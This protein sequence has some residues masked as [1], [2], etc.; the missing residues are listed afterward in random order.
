MAMKVSQLMTTDARACWSNESLD[1]AA[2]LMWERDCGSLPVLDQNGRVLGM[3]TDRDVCMAAYTQARLLGQIPVSEAMSRE[4]H[5]CGP[6]E[7]LDEVEKIMRDHQV[8]RLAV[9]DEKGHLRGIVSLADIAQRATKNAKKKG[10]TKQVDFSEVGQTLAAIT[11]P[12][13]VEVAAAAS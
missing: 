8:R 2:R 12:R 5:S 6:D 9:V 11:T 1:H 3:I 13:R 10:A 4:L 7:D